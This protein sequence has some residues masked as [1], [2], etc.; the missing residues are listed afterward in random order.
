M[1]LPK[2]L[3]GRVYLTP[4]EIGEVLRCSPDHVR[5]ALVKTGEL[6]AYRPSTP[7]GR[8]HIKVRV[9]DLEAYLGRERDDLEP[10]RP[11]R[12]VRAV[13]QPV[14]HRRRRSS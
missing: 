9:S 4:A 5:K 12:I 7:G 1:K 13:P 3:R 14:D 2:H 6:P 10:V 8:S 11:P